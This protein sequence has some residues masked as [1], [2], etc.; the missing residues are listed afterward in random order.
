MFHL[1]LIIL[2]NAKP[3]EIENIIQEQ[4][5]RWGQAGNDK[6]LKELHKAI[7]EIKN[8]LGK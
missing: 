6:L 8:S 4:L 7:E 2:A 1:Q 3:Q 5:K